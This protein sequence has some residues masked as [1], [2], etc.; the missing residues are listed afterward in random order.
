M[1]NLKLVIKSDAMPDLFHSGKVETLKDLRRFLR[2]A[3]AMLGKAAKIFPAAMSSKGV[4]V[5]IKVE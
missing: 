4:S 5:S 3:D 2:N 1:P